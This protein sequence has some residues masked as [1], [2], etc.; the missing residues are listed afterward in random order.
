M[1]F[2]KSHIICSITQ[3]AAL[4]KSKSCQAVG[5]FI[6][7]IKGVLASGEDVLISGFGKVCVREKSEHRGRNLAKGDAMMLPAKRV[8][9]F[10]CSGKLRRRCNGTGCKAG[11]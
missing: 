7:I 5:H 2:T 6:D 10:K 3:E 9:T 4:P 1:S 8:V 11:D